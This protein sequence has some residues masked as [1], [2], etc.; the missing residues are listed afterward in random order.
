MK[1]LQFPLARFTIGFIL[2]I[3]FAFYAKANLHYLYAFILLSAFLLT[4]GFFTLKK[5]IYFGITTYLMAFCLGTIT[6]I[7]HTD[8]FQ[9]NNYIHSTEVF[10]KPQLLS[11]VIREKLKSTTFNDRYIAI[12]NQ[13]ETKKSSGKII[14]NIHK[15]SLNQTFETGTY[16]KLNGVLVR[17]KK[18]DNPSQFD[19]SNYLEQKQMYAQLYADIESI[20]IGTLLKKDIWYYIS[21]LRTS[22]IHNLENN[23]FSKKELSVAIALIMGQRQDISP[24]IVQDYQYAGAIHILSVSGLHVGF[25]LLFLN[26]LLKPIP[27]SKKGALL[28]LTIIIASLSLFALIAGLSPSIVRSVTMFSFIAIGYYLR[29]TVNIYHTLLVSILLILLFQPS[30]LFDVGF[31]LSYIALFFIIWFQPLLALLWTPKSKIAKNIWG[32]LT[33]SFAAQI[34]TLPLSIYYF[35]QFPGLFFITNL[36]IIPLLS[37]IMV[38]GVIVLILAAFNFVPNLLAKPL[39]WSISI[40]NKIINTIA[41]FEQFVIHAIPLNFY[42]LL[43]SYFLLIATIIWFKK[44]KFNKLIVVLLSIITFQTAFI[45][46]KWDLQNQKE[47]IV[48]NQKRSTMIAERNGEN[49]ILFTTRS[50]PQFNKNKVLQSYLVNNFSTVISEKKLTNMAYFNGNKIIILDS[51]GIYPKNLKPD[52][53]ILTQSPKININRMLATLKPKIV[54]ADGSNYK[55]IQKNWKKSCVE[56]KIPF[57]ATAEKGYFKLN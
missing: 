2:G 34:G 3:L 49:T 10:E 38:L 32:A 45:K 53:I 4:I 52:I 31:Q 42:L 14:L 35:H 57:H 30:F 50:T 18:P 24:D 13:I 39:E 11:L 29:R 46:T 41:S 17:N 48:F 56:Q 51:S 43:S 16:L 55:S 5:P 1:V 12:I 47:W 20:Q 22:I 21:T 33:V 27:N 26:F 44:P 40:L 6:H 28:K 25:I 54:V 23:N 8:S 7:V 9:K 19:Y 36:I 37:F 15:D